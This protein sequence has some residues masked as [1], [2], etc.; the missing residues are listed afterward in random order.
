[1]EQTLRFLGTFWLNFW[2]RDKQGQI[3]ANDKILTEKQEIFVRNYVLWK[4]ATKAY[5]ASFDCSRMTDATVYRRAF[6]LKSHPK[7]TAIINERREQ[8]ASEVI[9]DVKALITDLA[10]ISNADPA[11]LVRHEVNNCR[12]CHGKGFKWQWKNEH[13]WALACAAVTDKNAALDRKRNA[14]PEGDSIRMQEHDP[15]PSDEGGYGYVLDGYPNPDC[16]VCLGEG[17]SRTVIADMRR[18]GPYEA[19]LYA[20]IK[21]TKDGIE[22]KMRDQDGAVDKLMR[23]LGAYKDGVPPAILN[24][25]LKGTPDQPEQVVSIPLNAQDAADFYMKFVKG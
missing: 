10:M 5:R 16:P 4:D 11:K 21:T 6:E 9:S 14:A 7:I 8:L 2:V 23:A 18:L 15:M 12:H 20:G 24:A 25:L 19:K 22:V 1:M 17:V 13:E 3:M